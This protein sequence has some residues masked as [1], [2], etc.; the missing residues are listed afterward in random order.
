MGQARGTMA[1]SS[2]QE[3][4][5]GDIEVFLQD[6]ILGL[7]P[8]RQANRRRGP[9][10]PP[11]LPSL[12][13]WAG[14]L[15]CVLR[16]GFT[17]QTALW[18]LL[19]QKQL[20]SYP[21][22]LLTDEGVRKR[23]AKAGSAPL[24]K[25]FAQISSLL[26]QRLR[27][28]AIPDLAPFAST[29]VALDETTLDKVARSLPALRGAPAGDDRLLP[30][31]LA[32]LFDIRHQQWLKVQ[33]VES[34]RQNE[35][36]LAQKMVEALPRASLILADLGYFGFAW[37]DW[38]TQSGHYFVS[39]LRAKTSYKVIHAH[40]Q[41][42]D[43]FDGLIHLGAYRADRAQEAVRL[44]TFRVGTTTYRYITN[45]LEPITL[46]IYDIARLY[47]YRWD[48][49]LAFKLIK[50]ELG[51][52]LLWSAKVGVILQQVWAVLIISQILQALRL[53]IAGRAGVDV[54]EV[55]M[56]LLAE[57]APRLAADGLDP[58]EVFVQQGRHLGF[59]R[60]SRRTK[61]QAPII[62]PEEI[63]PP[64]EGLVLTRTARHAN[65]NCGPRPKETN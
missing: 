37:F 6:A 9:G 64:P 45:V 62:P 54:F 19:C 38:L 18:R 35:K 56:P 8:D 17:S 7:E 4:V 59:I 34:A 53:E 55:S 1:Q 21:R 41:K 33:H 10:R 51:L 36:V 31:K 26:R 48:I 15:V 3:G 14:L 47:A 11:V 44:V 65:R 30:G 2:E 5:V 60:P 39:R 52:H 16:R 25:L 22:F 13:L 63:I 24:E 49:E 43:C 28:Y 50:R 42:G 57:Y 27:G 58:V 29:V 46:S 23:L 12:C 20:W 40:Y 32:G 61:I